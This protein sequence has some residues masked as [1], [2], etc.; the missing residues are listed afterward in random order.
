MTRFP[1]LPVLDDITHVLANQGYQALCRGVVFVAVQHLLDSTGSLVESLIRLGAQPKDIFVLGKR[2]SSSTEVLDRLRLLGAHVTDGHQ[3]RRWQEFGKTFD[4]DVRQM[5]QQVLAFTL[6]NKCRCVVVL[7]D[8]G[9]CILHVPK[10]LLSETRVVAVEQTTSGLRKIRRARVPTINVASSAAKKYI[11]APLVA[12]TVLRKTQAVS[13]EAAAAP[14][15]GV[16]GLGSVGA[17]LA[18]LLATEDKQVLAYDSDPSRLSALR[19]RVTACIDIA[20]VLRHTDVIFGCT[21]ENLPIQRLLSAPGGKKI[22]ISCSSE[23]REFSTLVQQYYRNNSRAFSEYE[24]DIPLKYSSTEVRILRGGFP[25]NFDRTPESVPNND[26][27]ITRGLLLGGIVQALLCPNAS[28]AIYNLNPHLQRFALASWF[29][30]HPDKRKKFEPELLRSF[31]SPDWIETESG[32]L[33]EP[34]AVLSQLF[35]AQPANPK[36]EIARA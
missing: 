11:E 24:A 15:V 25:I 19:S 9:H 34:C 36:A 7:D 21:G 29:T 26:I 1:F 23:D 8:G 4:A 6:K 18:N 2:Y 22:L 5:W 32:P 20:D 35:G 28:P 13:P 17:A 14:K 16:I 12:E 33:P 10:R 3:P 30:A 31:A 27:Q